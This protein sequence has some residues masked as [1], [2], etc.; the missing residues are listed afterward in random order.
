MPRGHGKK[1]KRVRPTPAHQPEESGQPLA[2]GQVVAESTSV[3]VPASSPSFVSSS[4]AIN[5]A[6]PA[7]TDVPKYYGDLSAILARMVVDPDFRMRIFVPPDQSFVFAYWP[8]IKDCLLARPDAFTPLSSPARPPFEIRAILGKGMG[9][10]ATE[11]IAPGALIVRERPLLAV[12]MT[13]PGFYMDMLSNTSYMPESIRTEYFSL[14]NCKP[15]ELPHAIGILNTNSV[16]LNIMPGQLD[17]YCGVFKSI[18][19]VNHSCSPNAHTRW[20]ADTFAGELR[21]VRSIAAGEEITFPYTDILVPRHERQEFLL[22]RYKFTCKCPACSLPPA[23]QARNDQARTHIDTV[24]LPSLLSVSAQG[25][26]S[27]RE[28]LDLVAL[29]QEADSGSPMIWR[30]VAKEL[31]GT[32]C[33]LGMREEAVKWARKAMEMTIA[34]TGKDKGWAAVV[35]A[36]ERTEVWRSKVGVRRGK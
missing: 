6:P 27:V 12:P 17:D 10:V 26:R 13:L 36:P 21:A 33:G 9:M 2:S 32:Y 24:V 23:A 20:D 29:L 31:A 7:S 4:P 30:I 16:A 14:T 3:S 11:A 18:C 34:H 1:R 25:T 19:R 35:E 15:P 5:P 28:L 8:D 22:R